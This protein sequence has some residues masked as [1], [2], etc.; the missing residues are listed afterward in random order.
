MISDNSAPVIRE[1]APNDDV[2]DTNFLP[3]NIETSQSQP[4]TSFSV[5]ASSDDMFLEHPSSSENVVRQS[6]YNPVTQLVEQEN[7]SWTVQGDIDNIH[8]ERI[9]H[10]AL[11]EIHKVRYLFSRLIFSSC[12]IKY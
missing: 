6:P 7:F 3:S 11:S 4:M 1:E 5:T 10:G 8:I 12:R 2:E 9:N